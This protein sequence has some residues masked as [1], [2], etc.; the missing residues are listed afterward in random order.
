MRSF[1]VILSM[2]LM[3]GAPVQAA[4]RCEGILLKVVNQLYHVKNGRFYAFRRLHALLADAPTSARWVELREMKHM[5]PI[6]YDIGMMWDKLGSRI[7]AF[8]SQKADLERSG[9]TIEAQARLTPSGNPIT[10]IK[11]HD[12]RYIVKDG[13]S[14]L[15]ALRQVF[16]PNFRVEVREIETDDY[17]VFYWLEKLRE[18]GMLTD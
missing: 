18:S 12:G 2:T 1:F 8:S 5:H 17:R 13:N 14:R 16:G 6:D 11:D 9:L 4:G 7:E 15:Y 10:V 3:L